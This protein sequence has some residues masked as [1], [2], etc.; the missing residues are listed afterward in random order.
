MSMEL[1]IGP[2]VEF[3]TPADYPKCPQDLTDQWGRLLED[4]ERLEWNFRRGSPPTVTV[5]GREMWSWCAVPMA[6]RDNPPRWP[7]LLYLGQISDT[8]LFRFDLLRSA[9]EAEAGLF[10]LSRLMDGI[11]AV[12]KVSPEVERG[13]V[14]LCVRRRTSPTGAYLWPEAFAAMGSPGLAQVVSPIREKGKVVPPNNPMH[15]TSPL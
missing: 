14:R 11:P 15:Q 10:T 7:L 3:L 5:R 6:I 9:P 1:F 13:L 8:P 12:E 4:T 2:Y